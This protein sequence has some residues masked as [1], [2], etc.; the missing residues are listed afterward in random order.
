MVE[1][2]T[3]WRG[4]PLVAEFLYTLLERDFKDN[5]FTEGFGPERAFKDG[6]AKEA[7]KLYNLLKELEN[8]PIDRS[9]T[10]E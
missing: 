5:I 3:Q 10:G 2:Q 9:D 4:S 1:L 6:Q 7:E 8:G